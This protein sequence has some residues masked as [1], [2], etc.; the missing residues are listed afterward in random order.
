MLA[1][2]LDGDRPTF[3]DKTR[4]GSKELRRYQQEGKVHAFHVSS[5][6]FSGIN[7]RGYCTKL[8]WLKTVVQTLTDLPPSK[9]CETLVL[10]RA[11]ECCEM[12]WGLFS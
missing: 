11:S 6:R 9:L 4:F 5:R 1:R 3:P 10:S 7:G 2:M 8:R 12:K